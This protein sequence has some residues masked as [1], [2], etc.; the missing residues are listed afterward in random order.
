MAI[1]DFAFEHVEKF[2]PHM[3]EGRK[4]VQFRRQGDHIGLDHHRPATKRM[5]KSSY[6]CPALVPRRSMVS[7]GP[8]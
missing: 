5:P 6:W 3:L 1:D 8:P 2:E 7:P 4:H